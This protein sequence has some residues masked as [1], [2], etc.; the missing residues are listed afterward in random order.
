[1]NNRIPRVS[2]G[3]P[4][5]NGEGF[6]VPA[7]ES[8]LAQTFPDFEL[9]ISDNASTD[10][11]R[12]I[13]ESYAARDARI[14]YYSSPRNAGAAP[15][16][17][18]VF[19]LASG[20]FF[21]WATHDDTLEPDFLKNCVNV[22]SHHT[23]V[24]LCTSLVRQIDASGNEICV[25]DVKWKQTNDADPS[26]RFANLVLCLHGLDGGPPH[27]CADIFGLIRSNILARTSLIGGYVSSDRI[28]LAELGLH[29]KFFTIPE[30]LF[31]H[32]QH[33]NRSIRRLAPR[34]RIVW[35][36]VT[37]A[38]RI[39]LPKW[40]R[41][42]EYYKAVRRAPIG[43]RYRINCHMVVGKWL[44]RHKVGLLTD[45]LFAAYQCIST[46][47]RRRRLRIRRREAA[48][49]NSTR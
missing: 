36:D 9:V 10:L 23:D 15:N 3:M 40:R 38:E 1:M 47:G 28:L 22:L 44:W 7:L 46:D 32:R 12:D 2:I 42:C 29:G 6:I 5:Y 24:V 34:Q 21:K 4:V 27:G 41:L 31:N 49:S 17:N 35:F 43:W 13:C 26:I 8:I 39:A 16:F 48:T 45:L 20:E 14:R 30:I 18:R 33:S 19:S 37:N 25:S 11:T